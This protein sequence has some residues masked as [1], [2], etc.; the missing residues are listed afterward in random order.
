MLRATM[1]NQQGLIVLAGGRSRRMGRDKAWLEVGGRPV[2]VRV[3]EAGLAAGFEVVVV[4]APARPLPSL[5]PEVVRVDDPAECAFD[6][7]L[8]GFAVGLD[9]LASRAISLACTAACDSP[10]MSAVHLRFMLEI[11]TEDED[12]SAVV[13]ASGPTADAPSRLLATTDRRRAWP[14]H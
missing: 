11:L 5:P 8:R 13:P 7:P 4:G 3:V 2:V 12:V 6:G 14:A 10:W 1:S 9:A